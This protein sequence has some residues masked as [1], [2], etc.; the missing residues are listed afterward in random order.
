MLQDEINIAQEYF[1]WLKANYY[2]IMDTFLSEKYTNDDYN[3][4]LISIQKIRD[5]RLDNE[6]KAK[7]LN[8]RFVNQVN[9]HFINGEFKLN[10]DYKGSPV[11]NASFEDNQKLIEDQIKSENNEPMTNKFF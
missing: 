2:E 8:N 3:R 11:N 9:M 5:I 10:F 6:T 7:Y 1:D 4:M